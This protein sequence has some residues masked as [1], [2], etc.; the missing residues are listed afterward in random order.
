MRIFYNF[1]KCHNAILYTAARDKH[2]FMKC[3][4]FKITVVEIAGMKGTDNSETW[5]AESLL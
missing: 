4:L 5:S 2:Y 3:K 1:N